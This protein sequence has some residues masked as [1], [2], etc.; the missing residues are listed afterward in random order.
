MSETSLS[1]LRPFATGN[2]HEIEQ[3]M[4]RIYDCKGYPRIE[5][6]ADDTDDVNLDTLAHQIE[7]ALN[8][9]PDA[10]GP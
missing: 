1:Y 10:T 5:V 7:E 2:A 4:V 9:G 3:G 6:Y 8:Q